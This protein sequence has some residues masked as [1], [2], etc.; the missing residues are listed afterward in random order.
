MSEQNQH[1]IDRQII[2]RYTD[3]PARMPAEVRSAVEDAWGG[4]A[5]QLYALSD[6]AAGMRLTDR[7]L[8]LCEDRVG[9][10]KRV[11]Q[12]WR[13]DDFERR[14]LVDIREAPGL[15]R[16]TLTLLGPVDEPALLLI[17]Y[18]HRQ[19]RSVENVRFVLQQELEGRSVPSVD[20]DS[21]YAASVAAPIREA[22]ALVAGN[23]AAVLIRLMG[24][25]G[26]YKRQLVAGFVA[27][28]LITA[29]S[30]VPPFLAGCLIDSVVR[31]VQ[32]GTLSVERGTYLARLAV[33]TIALVFLIRQASALVRLRYMSVLGGVGRAR[34]AHRALRTP[35]AAFARLLLEGENR[36]SDHAGEL[37][38]IPTLGFSGVR[39]HRCV[40]VCGDADRTEHGA[41]EPGLGAGLGDGRAGARFLLGDLQ[42]RRAHEPVLHTR[43]AEV[44]ARNRRALGYDPGDTRGEGLQPGGTRDKTPTK[45]CCR[46][47]TA[48]TPGYTACRWSCRSA[49]NPAGGRP[50]ARP[51]NQEA[52]PWSA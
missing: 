4:R 24:Y 14:R 12:A 29:V 41:L 23:Q 47:Q 34:P 13:V 17:R 1:T 2:E 18:T 30:L 7:W 20:A 3:Q 40:A 11:G 6:L 48:S 27:A 33:G 43:L 25:L 10:A 38:Y 28:T 51:E 36:K 35:A 49:R 8:V 42:A 45:S 50:G 31:P 37:G 32:D 46:S 52:L 21:Q 15:S 5:V 22:Q 39:D 9:I 26:R 19:Q 44:V 16:S